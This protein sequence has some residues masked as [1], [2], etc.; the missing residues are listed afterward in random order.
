MEIHQNSSNIK[1]YSYYGNFSTSTE[2]SESSSVAEQ[3]IKKDNGIFELF[4]IFAN[5]A[6]TLESQLSN[7][8]GTCHLKYFPD[9]KKLIGEYYNQRGLK[10]TIDVT[11]SQPAHLGRLNY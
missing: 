4:Y 7:H 10:G 8:L 1:V 6:N 3:I 2:T 5:D 9:R 11:F